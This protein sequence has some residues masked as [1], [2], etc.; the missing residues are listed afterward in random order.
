MQTSHRRT[1]HRFLLA[2]SLA[3]IAG[4][5]LTGLG[6]ELSPAALLA[7]HLVMA[8][9]AA[10]FLAAFL[11]RHWWP[12]RRLISQHPNTPLGYLATGLC[13]LLAISGLAR[14]SG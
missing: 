9:G 10:G 1:A 8:A 7:M 3:L 4:A 12:R 13:G 5:A 6:L 14:C 2:G 11:G